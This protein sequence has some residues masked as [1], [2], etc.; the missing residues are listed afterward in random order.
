VTEPN[1]DQRADWNCGSGLRWAADADRRDRVLAPVLDALL[2]AAE[3]QAGEELVDIGCG[4][5][6]ATLAAAERL[7]AGAALGVDIARTMLDIARQRAV[8]IQRVSFLEA[9]AQTVRF[10]QTFDVAISRFGTLFFDDPVGAF[11]NIR[12]ALRDGGRLC[13]ATWQPLEANEWLTLPGSV[14]RRFAEI[15]PGHGTDAEMFSQAGPAHVEAMLSQAGWRD[16]R[17]HSEIVELPM[18]AD[19]AEAA[20]YLATTGPGRRIMQEIDVDDHPAAL[21]AV[22]DALVPFVRDGAVRMSAGIN[23]VH[24]RF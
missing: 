16:V 15:P 10:E 8:G 11:R 21:A 4:C 3:L 17:V 20:D 9:D 1:V 23:I 5:G 6:A 7:G 14:L 22:A 12:G 2:A 24:G 19:A 13:I 18:G